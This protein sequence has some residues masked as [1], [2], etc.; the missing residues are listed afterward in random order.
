VISTLF[1]RISRPDLSR[2][3]SK[4]GTFFPNPDFPPFASCKIVA[5]ENGAAFFGELNPSE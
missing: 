2:S 3:F 1:F 4:S 5:P